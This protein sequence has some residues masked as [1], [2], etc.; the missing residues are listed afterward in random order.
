MLPRPNARVFPQE[1]E[2]VMTRFTQSRRFGF[3]L[4]TLTM[5]GW[6]MSF[7]MNRW[8]LEATAIGDEPWDG[9]TLSVFRY[10]V[11]APVLVVWAILILRRRGGLTAG[12][13]A[14]FGLLGLLG[15]VAYHLLATSAQSVSSSSLNAVL[16][17]MIPVI[18]FVGG[19]VFL[20][21][22]LTRLKFVGVIVASAGAVWYSMADSSASLDGDNIPLAVLLILLVGVAWTFYMV[23]AKTTLRRWSGLE[24]TVIVNAL[25][26]VMLIVLGEALRPV[27]LG[28]SWHILAGLSLE[29]WLLLAYLGLVAGILCYVTYNA[30]LK[31]VEASR[32]AVFEY[33]LVPVS[34]IAA[35]WLPGELREMP[36]SEKIVAAAIII[37]G[38]TMVTWQKKTPEPE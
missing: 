14:R 27:G 6:G 1:R 5:V 36:T 2:G 11:A 35:I 13:W 28:V 19:L 17:Q 3:I 23:A 21:E 9:L 29:G 34:M 10:A 32:A 31:I 8:M 38:V 4:L 20:R 26:A 30:G 24:F 25:G 22:R 37:A 33:L 15:V 18:A 12:Q 16:H 7:G